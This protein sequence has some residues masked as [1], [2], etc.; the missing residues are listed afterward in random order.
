MLGTFLLM[1]DKLREY[2]LAGLPESA[3]VYVDSDAPVFDFSVSTTEAVI[4]WDTLTGREY[5]L[6]STTNL[7][8]GFTLLQGGMLYP[9]NSYTNASVMT[10]QSFFFKLEA[11][12][13]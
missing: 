8:D 1:D 12:Q 13:P 9:Q 6:Y 11:V 4:Q 7:Y 2:G 10:N 3:S 5:N